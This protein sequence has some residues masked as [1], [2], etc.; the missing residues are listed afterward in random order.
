MEHTLC[1]KLR[2]QDV[3]FHRGHANRWGRLTDEALSC[4]RMS[5][6]IKV[7]DS[8]DEAKKHTRV[9]PGWV[10]AA[11]RPGQWWHL[12]WAGR[13]DRAGV[14]WF[15]YPAPFC[16]ILEDTRV[17]IEREA[18]LSQMKTERTSLLLGTFLTKVSIP[19]HSLTLV[20]GATQ[21]PSDWEL[22]WVEFL[23]SLK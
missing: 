22:E 12:G 1:D 2:W 8:K 5:S 20:G 21:L 15:S 4:W 18:R 3:L 19:K 23:C 17:V 16:F 11:G 13:K 14:R 7:N 9:F 10:R 6:L